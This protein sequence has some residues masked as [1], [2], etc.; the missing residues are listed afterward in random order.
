MTGGGGAPGQK[1]TWR[2]VSAPGA[3]WLTSFFFFFC[4]G[5]STSATWRKSV[6]AY[7]DRAT[8]ASQHNVTAAADAAKGYRERERERAGAREIKRERRA[9]RKEERER[10][11]E[12]RERERE[13]RESASQPEDR[14][15][16]ERKQ[17]GWPTMHFRR[18]R[19]QQRQRHASVERTGRVSAAVMR[20]D[21]A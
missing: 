3:V 13:E 12:K 14:R 6:S 1:H 20:C 15:R 18:R 9:R 5:L 11:R 8:G 4:P 16:K 10:E 7:L 17:R 2:C 21:A 19:R